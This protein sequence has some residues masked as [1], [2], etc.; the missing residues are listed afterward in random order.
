MFEEEIAFFCEINSP[1]MVIIKI[2]VMRVEKEIDE[3]K[4]AQ[5]ST[6]KQNRDPRA[7]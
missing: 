5:K 7:N 6:R 1:K 4:G 2:K 3:R